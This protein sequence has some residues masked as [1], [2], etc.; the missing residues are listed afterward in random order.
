[1]SRRY[2]GT[3]VRLHRKDGS[4][5]PGYYAKVWLDGKRLCRKAGLTLE[6]AEK[7][8][9]DWIERIGKR[10]VGLHAPEPSSFKEA[11]ESLAWH[12]QRKHGAGTWAREETRLARVVA[13]FGPMPFSA[14]RPA[15]VE[16][17]LAGLETQRG[18]P[19]EDGKRKP[20]SSA[21]RNRYRA[22]VSACMAW[23]VKREYAEKNPAAAVALEKEEE[24]SIPYQSD[25]DVVTLLEKC[26]DPVFRAF[27][28]VLADAGLRRGEALALERDDAD[29]VRGVIVV[30]KSKSKRPREIP[31]SDAVKAAL[32]WVL[33]A[34]AVSEDGE[35]PRLFA[36]LAA[37]HPSVVT[38]RF[39][40]LARRA[41]FPRLR[42]HD[43]RHG[44]CSR[45]AQRG[46]PLSTIMMLAGHASLAV[47]QRY[48]KH[49]PGSA[50]VSAIALLNA[51]P[52]APAAP[53]APAAT[54]TTGQAAPVV[55]PS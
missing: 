31:M 16:D 2:G 32:A 11:A 21:T 23:A 41:G 50:T 1:M 49:L 5:K 14:I 15:D 22:T 37:V 17:F 6:I 25:A 18:K 46:V 55:G 43:M 12:L 54:G 7:Y 38:G 8:L 27:V 29:M 10:G 4:D 44:F 28:R 3:I 47:T 42:L 36:G 45:L 30:R 19:D 33:A 35:P 20:V 40:R 9:D 24:L 39:K 13:H 51:P 34:P 26:G 52:P 48:A 53:V